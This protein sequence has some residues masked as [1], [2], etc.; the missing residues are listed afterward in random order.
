MWAHQEKKGSLRIMKTIKRYS[1][2]TFSIFLMAVGI[3]FFKF[4]DH[5]VFGG[6]TGLALVVA[7][8]AP[9][10]PSV[11]TF[12]AN[13]A[14]LII[15]IFFLGKGFTLRTAY[16]SSLLSVLLVAFEKVY[17]MTAPLSNEPMLD[18]IFA[19]ALP[20]IASALLFHVESS[21]GGTD[22]L[23]KILQKYT[24]IENIGIALFL[25]DLACIVVACFVF[26]MKTALYSFVGLTFKSFVIDLLLENMN[27]CKAFTIVCEEPDAI[28]DYIVKD[29]H[30]SATITEG[31][32]AYSKHHKYIISAV[33]KPK[34]A[35][36]LRQFMHQRVPD[37]FVQ[38]AN[39]SEI[40]GNGF[41]QV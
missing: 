37:S 20:G 5:F 25:I 36:D 12:W 13:Q 35:C 28:S 27:R 26:D 23:A 17:P 21:S 24:T 15:G 14:L 33:L 6:V 34:E 22:V 39:S 30:R 16:A 18:L 11:F 41:L 31:I 2:I 32:G 19:I 29:L 10:S 4:P 3:Y 7:K 40:L 1:I 8:V 9:I 38:V